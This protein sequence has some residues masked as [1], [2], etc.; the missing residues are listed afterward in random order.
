MKDLRKSDKLTIRFTEEQRAKLERAALKR[1]RAVG[2]L[3]EA[4]TLARE[5]IMAGVE[6]DLASADQAAA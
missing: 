4:G 6:R 5:Y 3:V 1:S 2:E